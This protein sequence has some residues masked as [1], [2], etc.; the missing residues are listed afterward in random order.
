MYSLN[1]PVPGSVSRL[2]GELRPALFGFE[3]VREDHTLLAKRIGDPDHF[4]AHTHEVRRALRGQPAFEVQVTGVDYFTEPTVGTAPVVYLA[5]ESPGLDQLHDRLV[6]EFG[7]IDGLEGEDYTP[8][9]TLARDGDVE[10]ARRLA[11]REIDPVTWTVTELEFFDATYREVAG[12][13]SL[14]A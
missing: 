6:E 10:T 7:A 9:V 14:P 11:E 4:D 1:V 2:A 12:R 8:H 13:V 3:R 5:V